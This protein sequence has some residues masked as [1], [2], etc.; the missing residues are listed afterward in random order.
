MQFKSISEVLECLDNFSKIYDVV[1]FVDPVKKEVLHINNEGECIAENICYNH[2]KNK[3]FCA[4]CISARALNENN[5]FVKIEY[6]KEKVNMVMVSP[7]KIGDR[8]CVMEMLK[9]VTDSGIVPNLKGKTILEINE[10]I[11]H[12]NKEVVTDPLTQ[13]FNRRYLNERLPVDIYTALK[14]GT[15]LSIIMLDIDFFKNFNDTYGHLAGDL[16]LK[17]ICKLVKNRI[18]R[19]LDWV[20]RFGGE[21]FLISLPG[22]DSEVAHEIAETIR[23]EIE[24]LEIEYE[25]QKLHV[26]ISAGVYTLGTEQLSMDKFIERADKNMYKAKHSGRNKVV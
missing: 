4:N 7:V 24:S 15:Q 5:T 2:W 22:A 6:N 23:K 20:A 8:R 19:D 17:E 9:D 13:V 3:T 26:T 25:E 18:R 16:V 14:F 10:I 21:E 1:R 12:L 11:E